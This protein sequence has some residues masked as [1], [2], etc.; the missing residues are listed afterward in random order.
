MANIN[1]DEGKNPQYEQLESWA[2]SSGSEYPGNLG[3]KEDQQALEVESVWVVDQRAVGKDTDQVSRPE[4]RSE[5]RQE[6]EG[7][8]GLLAGK[9]YFC[10]STASCKASPTFSTETNLMGLFFMTSSLVEESMIPVSANQGQRAT[11]FT[12]VFLDTLWLPRKWRNK[13]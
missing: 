3:E 11:C 13:R 7:W 8:P 10:S 12:P 2:D 9:S 6:R 4:N 1:E 5:R